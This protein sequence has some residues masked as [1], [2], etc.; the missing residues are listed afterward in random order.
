MGAMELGR[1][2]RLPLACRWEGESR[3][4]RS[5]NSRLP[6]LL[7]IGWMVVG[8]TCLVYLH[9]RIPADFETFY[10]AAIRLKTG[11]SATLYDYRTYPHHL[12]FLRPAWQA[13]VYLPLAYLPYRAAYFVWFPISLSLLGLSLWL[14]RDEIQALK[15]IR[16][17]LLVALLILP[18]GNAF[19]L[20]QDIT[21]F[22]LLVVLAFRALK[23]KQEG[24]SGLFLG[25]ASFKLHLLLPALLFLL[26]RRR[27]RLLACVAGV[28]G[29][30]LIVST[31]IGG[32][33]WIARC[34]EAQAWAGIGP[35]TL[36]GLLGELGLSELA[37]P[38]TLLGLGAVIWASRRAPAEV[39]LVTLVL[40]SVAL[41]WHAYLYDYVM[42]LPAWAAASRTD[43]AGSEPP[44]P[45]EPLVSNSR[46]AS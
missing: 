19:T 34:L 30:L 8:Y 44:A 22:L 7:L 38:A 5:R 21:L 10:S 36:R 11:A 9:S 35:E 14:L 46:S 40:A 12:P 23:N 2:T 6:A 45:K 3:G 4:P 43:A 27:W 26:G 32:P 39:A 33:G 28:G 13:L 31:L 37:L 18:V 15:P 17:V 24:R 29:I 42:I 1:K 41:N 25:L 20:G 16:R